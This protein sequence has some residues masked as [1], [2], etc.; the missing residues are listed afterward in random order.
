MS[1]LLL[2]FLACTQDKVVEEDKDQ[3]A[4]ETSVLITQPTNGDV[5][6]SSFVLQY[7]AGV[8]VATLEFHVDNEHVSDLDITQESTPITLD[9]G[10]HK[11]SLIGLDKN[12][13]WLSENSITIT[14][15][16]GEPWVTITS[17]TDG[18]VVTN[19]VN[20]NIN[21]SDEIDE[22]EIFAD[23]W[24]LGTTT[25]EQ[26]LSYQFQGI[27]FA[28]EIKAVGYDDGVEVAEHNITI[29]VDEGS[30]P[31]H[32]DFN[33]YVMDII[34]TYP[35]DGSYGY[36]W[37][38]GSGWLGT[39]ED[40]YYQGELYTEGDPNSQCYCVGLTFEVFMKAWEQV[41]EAYNGDGSINGISFEELD[42]SR[43][44]WYVR[45]INGMGPA[46]AAENYGIGE[47]VT[48]WDDV[49]PGDFIQFWRHSGSGHNAIFIDWELDGDGDRIG[50]QYW[51]TQGSTDGIG[52]NEEYFGSSGS[53][54]NSQ[55]F[56]PARIYT[57]ENWY[58]W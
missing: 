4:N 38:Q 26:I 43:K 53:Y 5:V 51:S 54:V 46:E 1:T 13:A 23:D 17:P 20:F 33:Q 28:R 30:A 31:L 10:N 15:D 57:P 44:D 48:S 42:E 14:V 36:Y 7:E 24:S 3:F 45:D 55:Y 37:P 32:S 35:T 2:T 49:N 25:P 9:A 12:D 19:P 50:F 29:T 41:D 22:I 52:Y 56:F 39:T 11:L 47:V 18:S 6:E 16:V 58:P 21:A 8:D 34:P 40:I 27:G